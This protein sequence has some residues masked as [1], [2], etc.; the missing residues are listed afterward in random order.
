MKSLWILAVLSAPAWA[1]CPPVTDRSAELATLIEQIRQAPN[2]GAAGPLNGRMWEIWLD[3]PDEPAQEIL[4]LGMR[5][6]NVFDL[7]GSLQ[8]FDRLVVYCP[9]YAEGY[10]QRAFTHFLGED[11]EAAL[12]DLD[13]VLRLSPDH[14]GAQSG[15]ALSLMN[16]GRIDEARAQL[17]EALDNNPWLS[18]RAL[19]EKGAALG[20]VGEDI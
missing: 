17:L 4:D 7:V 13:T 6:R 3:A 9:D 5:Q 15:R 16:L 2:A 10:N 20:P 14:V 19:L 18:E 8:S 1:E 12:V 11:Y